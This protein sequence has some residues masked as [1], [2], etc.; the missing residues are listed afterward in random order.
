V[1]LRDILL[2]EDG[3]P[4]RTK[5]HNLINFEKRARLFSV[6]QKVSV[7]PPPDLPNTQRAD[8]V[9]VVACAANGRQVHEHQRRVY[10]LQPVHQVRV[11]LEE[12]INAHKP[13]KE[14]EAIASRLDS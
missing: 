3:I 9:C 4:S 11:I 13:L 6:I 10:N 7:H 1:V 8:R 14:L 2:I 12:S 5:V